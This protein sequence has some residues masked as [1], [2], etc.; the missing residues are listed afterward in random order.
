MNRSPL[1]NARG[2]FL[3]SLRDLLK[4]GLIKILIRIK[5]INIAS[6]FTD[7]PIWKRL[8]EPPNIDKEV[9]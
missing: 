9:N 4:T 8:H 1:A 7:I 5:P 2:Y 3:L 6:D